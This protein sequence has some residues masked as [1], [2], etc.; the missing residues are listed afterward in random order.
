MNPLLLNEA[1]F[2]RLHHIYHHQAPPPV[3]TTAQRRDIGKILAATEVPDDP[4]ITRHHAGF[5]DE[6]TLTCITDPEDDFVFR[7]VIPREADPSADR[8]SLLTPIALAVIA[9]RE[10]A[11]VEWEANGSQRR[12][13]LSSIRK[14]STENPTHESTPSHNSEN[15]MNQNH[16]SQV[17]IR[18]QDGKS[19]LA[20]WTHQF[21]QLPT[22]GE[23]LHI[24]DIGGD[25]Q[26]GYQDST[27]VSRVDLDLRTNQHTLVLEAVPAKAGANRNVVFLNENYI[28]ENLRLEVETFIRRHVDQPAFEWVQTQQPAPITGIHGPRVPSRPALGQLQAAI[29]ELI[30]DTL[31]PATL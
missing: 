12:M 11:V 17:I 18:L 9:R 16:N 27:S 2:A 13:R 28:P 22:I 4:A 26:P 19:L 1:D 6:I 14:T 8:I 30:A 5:G 29:R 23:R 3:P 21:D 31:T 20:D 7:I 10:G 25:L 15:I 24:E